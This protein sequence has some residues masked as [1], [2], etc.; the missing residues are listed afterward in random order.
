L[1]PRILKTHGITVPYD[2][3]PAGAADVPDVLDAAI[4]AWSA[5]RI[6]RGVQASFPA[7]AQRIGAIWR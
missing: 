7:G 5:D 3:G 6:A 1:R 2:L 4:A